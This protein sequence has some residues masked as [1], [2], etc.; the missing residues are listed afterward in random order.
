[1]CTTEA[2]RLGAERILDQF[3]GFEM[4]PAAFSRVE[5]DRGLRA[6]RFDVERSAG[7]AAP[8]I[9]KR[10]INRR[11]RQ[12]SNR[13]DCGGVGMEEES[14]PDFFDPLGIAA[15]ELRCEMAHNHFDDR[16]AAGADRVRVTGASESIIGEY[17]DDRGLLADKSLNSVGPPDF[18]LKVNHENFN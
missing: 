11:E 3:S 4:K 15:D 6:T 8:H 16:T 12:G 2:G 17:A 10:S 1:L 5:R 14:T 7:P 13:A 18:G 9:P